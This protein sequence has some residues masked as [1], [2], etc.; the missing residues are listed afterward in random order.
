MSIINRNIAIITKYSTINLTRGG[1]R[2][3]LGCYFLK[4]KNMA[5]LSI[6]GEVYQSRR[7]FLK[8]AGATATTVVT[9]V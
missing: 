9:T 3:E 1:R 7:E 5:G 4:I 2:I 6:T 8:G